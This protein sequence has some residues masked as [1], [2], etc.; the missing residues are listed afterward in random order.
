MPSRQLLVWEGVDV[1]RAEVCEARLDDAGLSA[2]GTQIGVEPLPYRLDY[3]LFCTSATQL[4]TRSLVVQATGAGWRRELRL[5][6]DEDGGWD[7]DAQS[8]GAPHLP[9]AGGDAAAVGGAIDCDLGCCPLTNTMPVL[10]HNLHRGGE[11]TDFLMAWVSVPDLSLHP[12]K[13]R[14]E[15]IE[16]HEDGS[17]TV[18]Y[19][20]E[21][22]GFVGELELDPRGFVV[23]YPELARRVG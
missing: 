6:R 2:I 18:K 7:V 20:G 22:R 16:V 5:A 10:R 21:H 3:Q 17:S 19:V 23:F 9:E 12:S 13:Q 8:E 15:P 4:V 14:Y 11:A 1:W